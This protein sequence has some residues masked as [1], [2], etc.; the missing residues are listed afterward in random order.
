MCHKST[1]SGEKHGRQYLHEKHAK[2]GA[3]ITA[4]NLEGIVVDMEGEA[5]LENTFLSRTVNIGECGIPDLA[6]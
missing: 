3:F 6:I 1:I 4:R 2:S 5:D